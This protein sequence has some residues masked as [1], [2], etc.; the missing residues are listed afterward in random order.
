[1]TQV[2]KPHVCIDNW[3]VWKNRL[4]GE[5]RNHPRFQDGELIISS[6]I[7]MYDP[8]G[9]WIATRNTVYILGIPKDKHGQQ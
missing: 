5:V 3:G 6:P 4:C 8:A 1:M 9:S 7:D 2:D